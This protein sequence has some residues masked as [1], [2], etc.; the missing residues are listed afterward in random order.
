MNELQLCPWKPFGATE[1]LKQRWTVETLQV[2]AGGGG[3]L[4]SETVSIHQPSLR[5]QCLTDTKPALQR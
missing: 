5:V 4:P 1:V 2:Q 3:V